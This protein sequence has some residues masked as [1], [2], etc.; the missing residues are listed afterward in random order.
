M[1]DATNGDRTTLECF[2]K[3]IENRWRKLTHLVAEQ[4][5]TMRERRCTWPEV[6]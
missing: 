6:M 2:A 5:P 1:F 3:S 4:H